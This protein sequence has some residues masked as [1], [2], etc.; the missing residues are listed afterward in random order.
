MAS[1]LVVLQMRSNRAG[2]VLVRTLEQLTNIKVYGA[3]QIEGRPSHDAV[4]EHFRS[5]QLSYSSRC[6]RS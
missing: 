1:D 6:S 3:M 2:A 4:P 5:Q